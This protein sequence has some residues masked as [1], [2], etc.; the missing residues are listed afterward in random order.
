MQKKIYPKFIVLQLF[1]LF[2]SQALSQYFTDISISSGVNPTHTANT[3]AIGQA[4][5]DVNNDGFLDIYVTDHLG[6]NHL[7]MNQGNETFIE[8]KEFSNVN[9]PS[10]KC[11]GVSI[12]DFDNDGWDDIYVNCLGS[13]HLF[14]NN[15]GT[16]F[17]DVTQVANVDDTN[18][19]QVSA[20]ADINNDGWLDLY[21]ANYNN[22]ESRNFNGVNAAEDSFFLSNGDSTFTNINSDFNSFN[23]NKPGLAVT[24]FDYDNDG[25][26]DLYVVIDRFHGNVLWRNDGPATSSCG[27][28]WCFTDVST[29][30][31]T[32]A[33]I[34]GMGIATGDIDSDGDYD[35]YFTSI[36]EQI[37]LLNQISQGSETFV[38]ISDTSILNIP[39]VAGWGTLFFDYDNDSN[40]DAMIATYG[41][42][43]STSD[44]LFKGN[45]DS[46]FIDVTPL[47][48]ITD[49]HYT[50]GIAYGD[51]NN[52]GLLDILKGNRSSGY[53]LF[54]NSL[55]STNNWIEL[56]LIGRYGINKNAIGSRVN[57]GLSNGKQLIREVTS[58]DARGSGNQ[59]NLHFGLGNHTI[60]NLTVIWANGLV[61]KFQ[62]LS[63]N[64][65]NT[66]LY[67]SSGMVF[68]SSF[69]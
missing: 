58:G 57:I 35:M 20:W 64:S 68:N 65:K 42:T 23:L 33:E 21:V 10:Q 38:D 32:G 5:I 61:E 49:N 3:F 51:L 18:N 34:Y 4:W 2:N 16:S 45:G 14:K 37:I 46:T 43:P 26:Q 17:I 39:D 54:K 67:L 28:Y 66:V 8:M 12:A 55:V 62:N 47:A 56:E 24:F 48:G 15:M 29:A 53:K 22:G 19:S 36:G 59:L 13:N 27:V 1:I 7:L 9:L 31:N 50:E 25:D 60:N 6:P 63:I 52:D 44:K 40:L 30:T 69:E 11:V 41:Q